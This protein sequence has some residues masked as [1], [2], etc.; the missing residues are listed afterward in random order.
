MSES[1]Q[2]LYYWLLGL[3]SQRNYSF[4]GKEN[5]RNDECNHYLM[6]LEP[7]SNVVAVFR[8]YFC[9]M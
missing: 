6:C 5:K 3:I 1:T 2:L 7:A 8:K 9:F 4:I